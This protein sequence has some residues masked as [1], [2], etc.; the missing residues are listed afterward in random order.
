MTPR[1]AIRRVLQEMGPVRA[2][3]L[4]RAQMPAVRQL[5]DWKRMLEHALGQPGTQE[6]PIADD[7][8]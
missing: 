4:T 3:L 6:V 2:A 7:A 1:E 5:D 8:R